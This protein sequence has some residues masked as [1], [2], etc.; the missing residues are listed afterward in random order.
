MYG[1]IAGS[2]ILGIVETFT[3]GYISSIYKDF[4]SFLILILFLIIKPRG[5]FNAKVYDE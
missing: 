3:A 2:L 1:A 4:I 5:I